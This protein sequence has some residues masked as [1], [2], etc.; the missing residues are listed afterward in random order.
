MFRRVLA[1]LEARLRA[2]LGGEVVPFAALLAQGSLVGALCLVVRGDLDSFGYS[3]FVLFSSA[4]LVALTLLGE[5][6]S[7]LR[8][9]PAAA[10]SESL[11]ATGPE[12]RLGHGLAVLTLLGLLTLGVMIPAALLAPGEMTWAARGLL[13]AAG[14]G[15]SL[16]LGAALLACQAALGGRVEGL[17]VLLQTALVVIAVAGLLRAPSLAPFVADIASGQ[18]PWPTGLNWMPPAWYAGAVAQA[19]AGAELLAPVL[20]VLGTLAALTLL[21]FLPPAAGRVGRRS[22][23]LLARALAPF[24]ALAARWWVRSEERGIFDL[25]YGALPL[26][27]DFVLRTYPMI[28][29]PLAFLVAGARSAGG[30]GGERM[31]DLLALLLFTPAV[32]LPVLLA[33][34]PATASPRARWLVETAPVSEAA[35]RGGAIKA[36]AVR[37]L[38]PLYIAL[39]GLAWVYAGLGFAVRLAIPGALVTLAALR[40]LYP[41][42]TLA[43]PLS[44]SS[45]EIEVRHDWTGLLISIAA[46]LTVLAVAVQRYATGLPRT[47]ALIGALLCVE[48]FVEARTSRRHSV[49]SRSAR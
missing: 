25:V 2:H 1:L 38:L 40:I 22:E 46:L 6:G 14:L 37:F 30:E 28:G 27:R 48:W 10:W 35:I 20:L 24:R 45:E 19:P 5:F 34:V 12:R 47:L 4:G 39:G 26:E 3:L 33:Q 41:R 11:P 7:L 13:L 44:V 31:G 15:Q 16:A 43:P 29:I 36:L 17:L 49:S 9:D 8:A 21:V 32:Y 42:C 18:A 23:T